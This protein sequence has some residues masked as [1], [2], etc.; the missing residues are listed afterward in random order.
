MSMIGEMMAADNAK[1]LEAILLDAIKGDDWSDCRSPV[2][3]FA[4]KSLYKLYLDE[5]SEGFVM[6]NGEIVIAFE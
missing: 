1:R 6:P 3:A 4:K 2:K 5:C